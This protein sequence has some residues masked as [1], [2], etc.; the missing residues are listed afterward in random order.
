MTR[1]ISCPSSGGVASE[2]GGSLT[3]AHSVATSDSRAKGRSPDRHSYSTQPSEYTSARPSTGS[4]RIC[5]G[6]TYSTVPTS[7][8]VPV[9]PEIEDVCF[10]RPKSV[11]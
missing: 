4:P 2:G 8:P 10:V 3:W 11:R 6:E 7:S 1:S 5:S 9:S